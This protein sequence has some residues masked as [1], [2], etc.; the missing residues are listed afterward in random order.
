MQSRQKYDVND[1]KGQDLQEINFG[2]T[3]EEQPIL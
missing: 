2:S 1:T 3:S